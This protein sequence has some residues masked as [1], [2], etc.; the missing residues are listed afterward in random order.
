MADNG[1]LFSVW[2]RVRV[3]VWFLLKSLLLLRILS[4]CIFFRL[5]IYGMRFSLRIPPPKIVSRTLSLSPSSYFW[6]KTQKKSEFES[7][8]SRSV[9]LCGGVW[10]LILNSNDSSPRCLNG[11]SMKKKSAFYVGAYHIPTVSFAGQGLWYRFSLSGCV[12]TYICVFV[13]CVYL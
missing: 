6:V 4:A 13:F 9:R 8:H 2:R 10:Y 3:V 7:S 5:E 11:F 12:Y 1:Q